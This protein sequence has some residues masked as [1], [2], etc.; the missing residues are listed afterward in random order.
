MVGG[1]GG[2]GIGGEEGSECGCWRCESQTREGVCWGRAGG[3]V[4]GKEDS[5]SRRHWVE[6]RESSGECGR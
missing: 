3:G 5:V 6:G 4:K 1:W 2:R